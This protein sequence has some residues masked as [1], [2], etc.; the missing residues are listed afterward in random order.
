MPGSGVP[1]GTRPGS[2]RARASAAASA[3]ALV[4]VFAGGGLLAGCDQPASATTAIQVGTVAVPQ[5]AAGGVTDA[6]LVIRNRG[7]ADR[8]ISA[9]TSE[10]GRVTFRAPV[11]AGSATMRTVRDIGIPAGA[12]VRLVPNGYHLLITG[13]GPLR[14]GTEITLTLVFAR[15]GSVPVRA[16]ITNP[17]SSGSGYF[18][19]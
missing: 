9:R 7:A 11:V 13:A 16:E 19:S 4:C 17:Q 2:R 14:G 15:A 8:L 3:A 1:R 5:A 18:P 6:Y 10:G 12:I